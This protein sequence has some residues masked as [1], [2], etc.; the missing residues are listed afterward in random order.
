MKKV[1]TKI[2]KQIGFSYLSTIILFIISP[3]LVVLLTRNLSVAQYGIYAILA[4]TVNVA[5]VL[6]D[7]GLSQYIMSRLAGIPSKQ[8]TRAFL[9]ITTFIMVFLLFVFAAILFT[10]LEGII[11]GLLKLKEYVPEFRIGLAIILCVTLV[12]LFASYLTAKKHII[13]VNIIW[14]LSQSLWVLLLL[15][16]FAITKNISLISVMTWWFV[17]VLITFLVCGFMIRREFSHIHEKTAWNTRVIVEGLMFS[18]PLLVFI[19]GSWSI[20]IGNR[21]LLN[22]M[23]GSE[24]VGLFTL[25][26][27]LLGVIAQLGAVVAQTF[28][29]YIASAWNQ[30][31]NFQL[32]LNASA[33]YSL[34]II[35][36]SMAGLL[37]LRK[38]IV[39]LVSGT[40]YLEAANI[41]PWLLVYPLLSLLNYLLYQIILLRKRTVLI[42]IT[43]AIGAVLN[44]ALNL[45]LI[46]KF[47]IT[48][49]AI[50]T[51][52]SYAFVFVVLAWDSR[53]SVNINYSF[54]K[55]GRILFAAAVMGIVVW[56]MHPTTAPFKILTMLGGA[57]LYFIILFAT[58]TF[59][60]QEF[61]LSLSILPKTLQKAAYVIIRPEPKK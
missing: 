2:T 17:G 7:L 44:I 21:Y 55:I 52:V 35:I 15:G 49:S 51:V 19:T 14:L 28:F 5:G 53:K 48:G 18:L 4:V 13:T 46:P 38:E 50:A 1:Y 31:K 34:M 33:K 32:Y 3:F 58:R 57:V 16:F 20:E 59:S 6:L 47:G 11:L 26:Y 45:L 25:I 41:I 37:A 23:L 12:R 40:Q 43:Y 61:S 60:A 10:P 30:R 8:R 9:T 54:L 42:G 36:P 24:A 29:P 27:S 56:L 39:T 22:G